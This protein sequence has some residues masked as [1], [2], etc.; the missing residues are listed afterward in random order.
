MEL[1]DKLATAQTETAAMVLTRSWNE[2]GCAQKAAGVT[3]V[4]TARPTA[5]P[6]TSIWQSAI[7]P[8]L[9][10]A[11]LVESLFAKTP[12]PKPVSTNTPVPPTV[13][14]DPWA[15][16]NLKDRWGGLLSSYLKTLRTETG[17]TTEE[18]ECLVTFGKNGKAT[19]YVRRDFWLVEVSGYDCKGIE[20]W[21]I[22]DDTGEVTYQGS[23]LDK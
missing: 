6:A 10:S 9:T 15:N 2:S 19:Y 17:K 21:R 8:T 13:T 1:A 5:I 12:V 18:W 7:R 4:P 16:A 20:T 14:P 11:Q 23:T 22:E 3:K